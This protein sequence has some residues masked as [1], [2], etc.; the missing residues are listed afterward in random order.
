MPF[1]YR[2]SFAFFEKII[3]RRR[4]SV[5]AAAV[6]SLKSLKSL[7]SLGKLA[8]KNSSKTVDFQG[9]VALSIFWHSQKVATYSQK[10]ATYSQKVATYSQK[11]ALVKILTKT[12]S[13]HK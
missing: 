2:V 9:F 6:R 7:K 8:K 4:R 12:K 10:V 11:V 1:F 13:R 5:K 3:A